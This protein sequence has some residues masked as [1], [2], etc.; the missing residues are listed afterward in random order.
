MSIRIDW[1]ARTPPIC[2]KCGQSGRLHDK[3]TRR[4]RHLDALGHETQLVCGSALWMRGHGVLQ[5]KVPWAE[6]GSAFTAFR[7]IG[8]PG[9]RRV[10]IAQAAEVLRLDW[11]SV[12]RIVERAVARGTARRSTEGVCGPG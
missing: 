1:P 10:P 5:V 4:W 12:H 6:P 3:L 11:D 8:G 2:P 9:D 7:G